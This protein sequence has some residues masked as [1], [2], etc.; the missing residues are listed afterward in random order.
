VALLDHWG[1][2]LPV[3]LLLH[4]EK[5]VQLL[6]KSVDAFLVTWS[7]ER[8]Q[9]LRRLASESSSEGAELPKINGF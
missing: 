4:L 6:E 3:S 9:I 8:R 2:I 5:V 1:F 7:F